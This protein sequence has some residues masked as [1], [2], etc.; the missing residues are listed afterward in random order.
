MMTEQAYAALVQSHEKYVI[1]EESRAVLHDNELTEERA[2]WLV[3][4]YRKVQERSFYTNKQV[5]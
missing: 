1:D 2:A 4:H 5:E 3:W